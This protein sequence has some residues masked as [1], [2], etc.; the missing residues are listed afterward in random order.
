GRAAL[1]TYWYRIRAFNW[2]GQSP[3]STAARVTIGP[4]FAPYG[5]STR[6]GTTNHVDL[7]W[8]DSYGDLDG[9]KIERA[10]D[11]SGSPGTWAQIAL[12]DAIFNYYTDTN[13][14]ANTTYWYRVRAFNW[15]GESAPTPPASVT[16]VLPPAPSPL[17]A[18]IG[19]TN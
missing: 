2:I 16:I 3:Y 5:L 1:A 11:V 13:R 18:S 6:M 7:A 8:N 19:T 14:A 4:P 9:F 17:Y 15:A 10:P 12:V